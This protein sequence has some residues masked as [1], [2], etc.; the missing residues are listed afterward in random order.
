VSQLVKSWAVDFIIT[1][2]DNNYMNGAA[3]TI[4]ANVGQYY[5]E[6]IFP[7]RG[8]FGSGGARN[9]FF[10]TLGN[11]DWEAPGAAPYL[12]YFTLPGNERYYD[13]ARGPAHFFAVDSDP[14]EP[15][16][17]SQGSVQAQWLRN[18]LAA[19]TRPYRFV[20]MHQAPFS[21]GPNGSQPALQWPY[22]SWGAS[23]IIAGHDHFYE[24]IVLDGFPYF[25]NG[26]GGYSLYGFAA[27]VPGSAVRYNADHGAML[28]EVSRS[29][30]VFRFITRTGALVDSF[31]VAPRSAAAAAR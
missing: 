31:T 7:Y 27:P 21:S 11:H 5:S 15:D 19:S 2:G 24:R 8:G 23:A 22:R 20:Y 25:V 1:T 3:S 16:G 6:F 9:R 13:F 28:V 17:I 14:H 12:D 26:A 30:A 10:P 4:D 29:E 18:G